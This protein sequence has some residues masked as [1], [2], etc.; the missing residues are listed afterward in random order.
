[1]NR[2]HHTQ[3]GTNAA[4]PLNNDDDNDGLQLRSAGTCCRTFAS[5]EYRIIEVVDEARKFGGMGRREE[6]DNNYT[7]VV[8]VILVF[9]PR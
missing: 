8:F 5:H 2:A 6:K 9:L 4:R 7:G 3:K 1:L